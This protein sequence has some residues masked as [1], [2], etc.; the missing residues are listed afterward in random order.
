MC[1]TTERPAT[2][3]KK[4]VGVQFFVDIPE[5][6]IAYKTNRAMVMC[7]ANDRTQ[8]SI[9]ESTEMCNISL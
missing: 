9:N 8:S 4:I 2:K 5:E 3:R 6:I 1:S 7:D